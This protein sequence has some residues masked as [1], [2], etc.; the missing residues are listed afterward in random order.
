MY[1]KASKRVLKE[2]TKIF[3]SNRKEMVDSAHGIVA[4]L[5]QDF[6]MILSNSEMLEASEVARDHVRGILESVD[7]RF[8]SI[9]CSGPMEVDPAQPLECEPQQLAD[10]SMAD[11]GATP[12][13]AVEAIPIDE[14][15][16]MD[17]PL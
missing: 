2:L 12:R 15:V 16:A 9:L 11:D 17:T 13:D 7:S 4:S 1:R 14:D 8:G 3:E 10:A 6:E 5:Q